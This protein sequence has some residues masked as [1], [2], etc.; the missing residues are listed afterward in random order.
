[1]K[2]QNGEEACPARLK[3]NERY[4]PLLSTV[5]MYGTRAADLSGVKAK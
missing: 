2:I 1:M 5:A 3:V 4:V